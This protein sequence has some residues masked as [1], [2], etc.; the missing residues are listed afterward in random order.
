MTTVIIPKRGGEYRRIG[1]VEVLWKVWVLITNNRLRTSIT[2]HDALHGF[3]QARGAG[4]V[5]MEAELSQKLAGL[6]H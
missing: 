5:T 1:L 3:R 2:L 4:M 6:Y